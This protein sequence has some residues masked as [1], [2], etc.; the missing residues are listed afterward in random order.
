[1]YGIK[2]EEMGQLTIREWTSIKHDLAEQEAMQASRG[3]I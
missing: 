2:P 1:V 3:L